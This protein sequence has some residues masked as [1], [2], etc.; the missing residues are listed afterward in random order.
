[1]L[2]H[3]GSDAFVKPRSLLLRAYARR[4]V[5]LLKLLFRLL[6]SPLMK[7]RVFSRALYLLVVKPLAGYGIAGTPLAPRDLEQFVDGLGPSRF[8]V[9][10]CRC[11]KA[12][13]ACS[14][15]METDIYIRSGVDIWLRLF[16]DEYRETTAAEVLDICRRS[17]AEGMAQ[18]IYSHLDI[19]SRDNYFVICNCC[20]DG[21]LPLLSLAFYGADSYPFHSGPSHA[22][23]EYE[24]CEGC[25]RCVEVC[26][27][28]ARYIEDG[29][30]RLLRCKGCGLCAANCPVGAT[31]MV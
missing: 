12:H 13:G 20:A 10:P 14:H 19:V 26:P 30:S 3:I 24:R 16:P 21:C 23:I 17:H 5:P 15:S 29:K 31:M 9:G 7:N 22:F 27:F 18:I 1:M 25:G 2:A 28:G 8:A 4:E 11:R 6:H